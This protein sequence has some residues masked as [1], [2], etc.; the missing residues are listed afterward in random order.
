MSSIRQRLTRRPVT[1]DAALTRLHTE[2][3]QLVNGILDGGN[4]SVYANGVGVVLQSPDGHYW[5]VSVDN[6][7]AL[8]TTDLGTDKP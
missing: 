5:R 2:A 3:A 4:D 1:K 7:G 6:T 8:A